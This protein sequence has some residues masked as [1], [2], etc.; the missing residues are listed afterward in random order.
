MSDYA[1]HW[2]SMAAV[3]LALWVVAVG[4]MVIGH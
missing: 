1:K 2:L 4:N 3:V